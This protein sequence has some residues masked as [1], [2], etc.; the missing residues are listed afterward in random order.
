MKTPIQHFLLVYDH[1]RGY[2]IE[3]IEFGTDA[4][5]A[6]REYSALESKYRDDPAMDI[7]LV[8][9]DSLDTI[10]VTH[11]N[12]F[13]PARTMSEWKEFLTNFAEDAS[14]QLVNA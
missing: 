3:T 9:S 1:K 13:D 2:L 8:G 4:D 5:A 6:V 14:Q 11:R 7:V 10:K 12:Y